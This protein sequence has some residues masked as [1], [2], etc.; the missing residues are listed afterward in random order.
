MRNHPLSKNRDFSA[1]EHPVDLRPACKLEFVRVGPVKK[2]VFYLSWFNHG[3]PTKFENIVLQIANLR[4]STIFVDFH[5]DPQF[6]KDSQ[7]MSLKARD[8]SPTYLIPLKTKFTKTILG[9]GIIAPHP[10]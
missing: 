7:G 5:K 9:G 10:P 8:S 6:S 2:S 4:F 1:S 3:G